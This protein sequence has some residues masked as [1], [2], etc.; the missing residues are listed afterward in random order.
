MFLDRFVNPETFE[1]LRFFEQHNDGFAL[2]RMDM[3]LR[4]TGEILGRRQHGLPDITIGNF[5]TDQELLF[6]AR[7]DALAVVQDDP[8]LE[9]PEHQPLLNLLRGYAHREDL[10]RIG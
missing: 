3:K 5:E 2:A 10:L 6:A 1:R 4:G 7:D 8:N 9:R